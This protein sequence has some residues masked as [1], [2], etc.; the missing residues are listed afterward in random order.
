[1]PSATSSL[2]ALDRPASASSIGA[3]A[4]SGG[5]G[6]VLQL[7]VLRGIAILLVLGRHG[8]SDGDLGPL[9]PLV[10]TWGRFGWTGVDLFFVLS[11]FLIGGLIFTEIRTTGTLD[12]RRFY[13]RRGF[14]ILPM[15]YLFMVLAALEV[16]L[17]VG[18]PWWYYLGTL[19]RSLFF[20]VL[21]LQNYFANQWPHTWSLAVEEHFYLILPLLVWWF[22]LRGRPRGLKVMSLGVVPIAAG[23]LVVGC[24][25]LRC[26]GRTGRP[27]DHM[28][29]FVATQLRIDGLFFGVLIAYLYQFK[30]GFAAWAGRHH[31]ALIAVGLALISPMTVLELEKSW[32]VPTLGFAFLY[33]GYGLI[34]LGLVTTPIGSGWLGRLLGGR[35]A[36][37]VAFLGYFSYPIYLFHIDFVREP[38]LILWASPPVSLLPDPLRWV[39]ITGAFLVMSWLLGVFFYRL[40]ETPTLALRERWFPSRTRA[41]PMEAPRTISAQEVSATIAAVPDPA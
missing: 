28:T 38:L 11:G 19:S 23:L 35:V 37:A 41:I 39:Y 5:G 30:T 20:G 10:D 26:W 17:R 14:K 8:L 9:A 4:G 6:R 13:V 34:L 2:P 3:P 12:V 16:K 32:F 24:T 21:Q 1:M 15:Y 31:L 22:G 7:D 27:F 36:Q 18:G 29:H 33:V 25:A 40:V